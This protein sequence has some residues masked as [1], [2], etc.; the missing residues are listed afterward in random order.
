METLNRGLP[1]DFL[2]SQRKKNKIEE[3]LVDC[4]YKG[5][6]LYSCQN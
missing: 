5:S 3:V 4:T 6:E 2:L 1:A